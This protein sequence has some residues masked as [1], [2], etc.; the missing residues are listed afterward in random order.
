MTGKAVLTQGSEGVDETSIRY[1]MR[2]AG[3]IVVTTMTFTMMQFV[4]RLM[5]SNLGTAALAA[6]LPAGF[7]GM[8]PAGFVIGVLASVS[9]FV[10][11]SMGRGRKAELLELLLAGN[12]YGVVLFRGGH[13]D[14]V[15]VGAGDI[16][17]DGLYA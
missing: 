12:I 4:D 17:G 7:I 2:L 13:G 10:S 3:P 15:A 1:M 9:T 11:Q 16:Y 14:N 8:L 6:V 5:V